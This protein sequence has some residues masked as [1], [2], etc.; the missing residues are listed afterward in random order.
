MFGTRDLKE[1]TRTH[2]NKKQKGQMNNE[3]D[4]CFC[5]VEL[6]VVVSIKPR[7]FLSSSCGHPASRTV[8]TD[9]MVVLA[10][11]YLPLTAGALS[12]LLLIIG[13]W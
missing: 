9:S 10:V 7:V 13:T 6:F 12:P 5:L 2:Q 8:H 4:G 1:S 3:A 11:S